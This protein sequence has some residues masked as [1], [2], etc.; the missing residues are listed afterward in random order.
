MDRSLCYSHCFFRNRSA[1]SESATYGSAGLTIDHKPNLGRRI[2]AR[3][4]RVNPLGA[5]GHD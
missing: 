2:G 4:K 3:E 5:P 1:T